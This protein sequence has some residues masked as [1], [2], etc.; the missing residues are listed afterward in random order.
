M[1][2]RR[3]QLVV[4]PAGILHRLCSGPWRRCVSALPTLL[5]APALLLLEGLVPVRKLAW[6]H[7]AVSGAS[8]LQMRSTCAINPSR[9]YDGTAYVD[10]YRSRDKLRRCSQIPEQVLTNSRRT[11]R[12]GTVP[13]IS[14]R[15]AETVAEAP[16]VARMLTN[17]SLNTRLFL[18]CRPD[19]PCS[20][21]IPGR[22]SALR[23]YD[24]RCELLRADEL[25][26]A[27]ASRAGCSAQPACRERVIWFTAQTLRRKHTHAQLRSFR[28]QLLL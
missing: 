19:R 5:L 14:S 22:T 24:M 8:P 18:P 25:F 11:S 3:Y 21:T 13:P 16:T 2:R 6:T 23:K 26:A 7:A 10:E 20:G 28:N 4:P 17:F 1:Q 9:A 15:N 27:A 12:R